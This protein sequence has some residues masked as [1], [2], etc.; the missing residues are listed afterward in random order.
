MARRVEVVVICL[1][2]EVLARFLTPS[3]QASGLQGFQRDTRGSP[4]EFEA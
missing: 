4:H 1:G 2:A 3:C